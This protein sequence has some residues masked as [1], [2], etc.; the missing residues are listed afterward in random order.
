MQVDLYLPGAGREGG[1]VNEFEGAWE[2]LGVFG[3]VL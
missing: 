3:N 2:Y 1:G